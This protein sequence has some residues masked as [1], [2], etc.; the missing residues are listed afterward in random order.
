MRVTL[1]ITIVVKN[2]FYHHNG[3]WEVLIAH[4]PTCMT[5]HILPFT[6]TPATRFI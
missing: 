5:I 6:P 2:G 3:S 4:I 1:V